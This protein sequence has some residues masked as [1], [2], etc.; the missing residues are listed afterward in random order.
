MKTVANVLFFAGFL[1]AGIGIGLA[2]VDLLLAVKLM[3]GGF[4]ITGIGYLLYQ[5]FVEVS[6]Y[7]F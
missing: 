4:V 5:E 6:E 3:T 7:E 1:I 2:E